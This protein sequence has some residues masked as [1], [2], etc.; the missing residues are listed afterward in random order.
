MAQATTVIADTGP[1]P[2]R[3][4]LEAHGAA[5]KLFA[6]REQNNILREVMRQ[7]GE[8]Y[9]AVFLPQKFDR[10]K[11][12]VPPGYGASKQWEQ[13][14]VNL[15]KRGVI[16][17]PQPTPMV[18]IGIMRHNVLTKAKAEARATKTRAYVIIRMPIG[19]AIR[20]KLKQVLRWVPDYEIKR[21]AQVAE[22]QLVH[23]L[24]NDI[25]RA[26]IPRATPPAPRAKPQGAARQR[27]NT[28]RTRQKV[29]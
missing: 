15:A 1:G 10:S 21:I 14:K 2:I 23:L 5:V 6:Q 24:T 17:G 11:K 20:P 26:S 29:A 8:F 22:Q 3:A 25:A 27:V 18:Y 19:H 7:V 16:D 28:G 4:V 13:T 12:A 9:I